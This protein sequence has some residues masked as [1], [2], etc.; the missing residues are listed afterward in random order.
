M[1]GLSSLVQGEFA[2]FFGALDLMRPELVRDALLEFVPVLVNEYG[3]IGAEVAA[4]WYVEQRGGVDDGFRVLAASASVS[5]EDMQDQTRFLAGKLWTPS[6]HELASSLMVQVDKWVRQPA[7]DTVR[8]NAGREGVGWARVPR[9]RK[10][11]SWC[12]ILASRD[13]VYFSE[14]AATVRSRD[15][16]A[17]HGDCDCEAVRIGIGD[18]YP[19]DYLPG[20]FYN[21]YEVAVDVA[22][23]D[24]DVQAFLDTLDPDDPNRDIKG[25][26][27][28]MRKTFP[29]AVKDGRV[30]KS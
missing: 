6:P 22:A 11:C 20:D 5:D 13:A 12:L 24:P 17:F 9:G 2:A 7:R 10:T 28:A 8:I 23:T 26:T 1:A 16:E 3:P 4:D 18:E 15:G 21:M 25:A 19:T 29:D 14:Q 30:P 27:F